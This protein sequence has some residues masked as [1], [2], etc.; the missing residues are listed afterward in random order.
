M[1]IRY[2]KPFIEKTLAGRY[3]SIN[4][5]LQNHS[6]MRNYFLAILCLI[7]PGLQSL[8]QE[9]WGLEKCIRVAIDKNLTIQQVKLNKAGYDINGKQLRFEGLPSLNASSDFGVSFGRVINPATNDFETENSLYQSMG[10]NAGVLV[11]NGFRIRNAIRQNNFFVD[12]SK[13][14]I[15]QAEN[16]LALSVALGYL[17]VLFAYENLEIAK[18]R[19]ELTKRQLENMDKLILAGA[20]P[21]N[22]RYDILSQLAIDEQGAITAQ[23]N[24]DINM[25]ALKQ[26]MLMEADEP[27]ELERPAIDLNTLEALENQT[28]EAVYAAALNS[29]PQIFAAELRQKAS[30]AGVNMARAQMLPSLSVGGNL[31][32]N[33]SDLAKEPTGGTSLIKIPQSGIFINGESSLFEVETE[34]PNALRVIPYGKQLDNNIGYG[35]GASISI[36]IFNNYAAKAS[37]EQA[38]IGVANAAIETDKIKQTLKT[39]VQNALASARASRK[40]LEG[41][42]ASAL[43]AR[44]ALQ[45]ADRRAALGTLSNFEYLSARNRSDIAEN[46]LLIARYDYYFQVKVIEYYLGRGLR[47]N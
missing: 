10:I 8:A 44:I 18:D 13:E 37:V 28:F 32:S 38:K 16:D 27:L 23:N 4:I 35:V 21:E 26:Q 17:N 31:G 29:Q 22:D 39:S 47:I 5:A 14:D 7:L 36:P 45:N 15:R 43:A 41:A 40:S 2:L 34:V 6:P 30:E 25:L 12:A 46:N 20:K 11:F 19:V 3:L 24:I 33:W 1:L 42:E 9:K